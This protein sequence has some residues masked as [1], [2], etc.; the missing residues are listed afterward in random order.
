[1]VDP[2]AKIWDFAPCKILAQ[3][4]GGKF[5]N[6]SGNQAKIDEGTAIVGNASIVKEVRRAFSDNKSK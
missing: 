2:L 3:E 1:M 5:A 6:F 4:A